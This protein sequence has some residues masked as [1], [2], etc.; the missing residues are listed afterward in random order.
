MCVCLYLFT[1]HLLNTYYNSDTVL[2]LER[3][4]QTGSYEG[5]HSLLEQKDNHSVTKQVQCYY[6]D[7]NRDCKHKK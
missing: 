7:I 5:T 1:Q 2:G 6:S 4:I 3:E